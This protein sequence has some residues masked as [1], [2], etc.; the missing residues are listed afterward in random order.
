[1]ALCHEDGPEKGKVGIAGI[2]S[3]SLAALAS[4][5]AAAESFDL[6]GLNAE[7]QLQAG[8]AAAWRLHDPDDRI[9]NTPGSPELPVPDALKYPESNQYDDGDRNFKKGAM[10][11]NRLTVLGELYF[12]GDDFGLLLR[13]DAFYD[14]V[15]RSKNDNDSRETINKT[16]GDINFPVEGPVNEF[17]D[18]AQYRSGRRARL[19]DAFFTGS[20]TLG[21][22]SA[23]NLR[24]GRHIAAWG[25]SL[26]FAGVAL[27][28]SPADA[29]K[30]N[31]P[32]ADVK[33]I[34]LPVNQV[35]L[36]VSVN[37]ELT[38]L[39]QYKLEYSPTELNPPG[40]YFAIADIIGPGA[41]FIYGLRNPLYL[42]NLAAFNLASGDTA[43]VLQL[44]ADF[45]APGLP[46]DQVTGLLGNVLDSIDAV[47]PDL[48]LP[49]SQLPQPGTPTSINVRRER[50]LKPSDHGQ[51]GLGAKYQ[52]TPFTTVGLYQLRY[53][54]TVPAPVQ[55]YGTATL[56][57]RPDGTPLVTTDMLGLPVPV[58]YNTRYFDGVDMSALSFSTALFGANVA[59]EVVYRDGIDVLVDLDSGLLGPVPTPTRA[60]VWQGLVSS[61]YT[62]GPKDLFGVN[63][64]DTFTIV[65]EGGYI[66]VEDAEETCNP[67]ECND[68]LTFSRESAGLSLL[69]LVDY[70]NLVRGWDMTIPIFASGMIK[71]QSSLLSGFG[72]LTGENDK[73][74]SIG[75][76]LTYLQK[77][78]LGVSYAGYYGKPHFQEN[79][80]ADRDYV[81][82]TAK[83]SF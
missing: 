32:G 54:S 68:K 75:V 2:I 21:E 33:S 73:R 7:Y 35:S 67:Y 9:I 6:F 36:Q 23:M 11:N 42:P 50:D 51:W 3:L 82:F 79:S 48:S 37:N 55:N 29:T 61:L 22:A 52:L 5:P 62:I 66:I 27:A 13:G 30:A 20:W 44:V 39:G 57:A 25:E 34:L 15:Y 77:L 72:P 17:S 45:L 1:M 31:V 46:A 40:E 74:A 10:V 63:L 14:Q 24:V 71:G 38:L 65:G 28:Q 81:G 19:L 64:W 59:G 4:T 80:Y 8:Y 78:T 83:Y 70:K 60:K 58:T 43:E 18:N 16:K 53:H 47:A 56:L 12:G 49:I 69:F 76:N 26:F 41:Q